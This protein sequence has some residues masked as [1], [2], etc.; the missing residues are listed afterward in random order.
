MGGDRDGTDDLQLFLSAVTDEFGGLRNSLADRLRRP[1][2]EVKVQREFV[3]FG[4]TTLVEID[5]Y[6][7]RC[8]A[9]V[10]LVGENPGSQ[11]K[12]AP[13]RKLR[14]R[15]PDL[16]RQLPEIR[17]ELEAEADPSWSY[18]MWEA[19]LAALHGIKLYVCVPKSGVTNPA[20]LAHLERLRK[21]GHHAQIQFEDEKDLVIA[22]QRV[23]LDLLPRDRDAPANL[24]LALGQLFKGR[25]RDL[26]D[27]REQLDSFPDGSGGRVVLWGMGGIGKTQLAA[28][29]GHVFAGDY[30]Q[31]RLQISAETPDVLRQ[32]TA[33]LVDVLELDQRHSD[34]ENVRHAAVLR[35]L[36]RERGWLLVVDNAD[37]RPSLEAVEQLLGELSGLGDVIITSRLQSWPLAFRQIEI[38][39]LPAESARDYLLEAADKRGSLGEEQD[40]ALAAE[41]AREL[42]YLAL[43]L[44]QAAAFLNANRDSFRDYLDEWQSNRAELLDDPD[45]DP[46]VTGYPRSVATTWLTSYQKL[47]PEDKFLLDVLAWF[48]PEPIPRRVVRKTWP[49]K[50]LDLAP[51]HF[52]EKLG[53]KRALRGLLEYSLVQTRSDEPD[54]FSVHRLVQNVG[55]IRQRQAGVNISEARAACALFLVEADFVRPDT[56]S[57]LPLHVLPELRGVLPHIEEIA[58]RG[59]AVFSVELW[60]TRS[61][62][63]SM[64]SSL[65]LCQGLLALAEADAGRGVDSGRKAVEL[66]PRSCDSR[67]TLLGAL[68][69]RTLIGHR[70]GKTSEAHSL[71]N[72]AVALGENLIGDFADN[73]DCLGELANA[74]DYAGRILEFQG[75]FEEAATFFRKSHAI[76]EK[77]SVAD[78]ENQAC[79]RDLSIAL[80]NLGRIAEWQNDFRKAES[81]FEKSRDIREKLL[82][83]EPQNPAHQREFSIACN[84]LGRL[85]ETQDEFEKAAALF[86]RSRDIRKALAST[87]S[88]NLAYQRDLSISA[89]NLGRVAEK[90]GNLQDAAALFEES[91]CVRRHLV[92]IEPENASLLRENSVALKNSGRIAEK[93]GDFRKAL[94]LFRKARDTRGRVLQSDPENLAH[95]RELALS[96]FRV[97][98]LAND[99]GETEEALKALEASRDGF[100][101]IQ[102]AGAT[103]KDLD[104]YL[105]AV[106]TILRSL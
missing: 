58:E 67:L 90:L 51:A 81:L 41:I 69:L 103:D 83:D 6:I 16:A 37:D 35:W 92:E 61:R 47:A 22:V 18:T 97:G 4:E 59:E 94:G 63:Q 54:L 26:A 11:A 2:V 24:D 20:Q 66:M 34:D 99:L 57:N 87:D 75:N 53:G 68:N 106:E 46:N 96:N 29:F 91:E 25:N 71:A 86:E 39:V 31:A 14:E 65:A 44:T 38:P 104:Q 23:L 72:E 80:D 78:V 21:L 56:T 15:Y 17:D 89:E 64:L 43:G 55:R 95:K 7:S 93:M 40:R 102:K 36:K 27:I 3:E 45:F 85:A 13:L 70:R 42:G 76:A 52:R 32:T 19:Y 98:R 9:L 82:G 12:P 33:N 79:Q 84:N 30:P 101:I 62:I 10:H 8:G 73:F 1:G 50:A 5:S 74:Y 28:E 88:K 77:R 48:A 105:E 49:Q 60:I 100:L